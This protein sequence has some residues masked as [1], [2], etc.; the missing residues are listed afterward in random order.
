[1]CSG[2][3]QLSLLFRF[4]CFFNITYMTELL[5]LSTLKTAFPVLCHNGILMLG[6]IFCFPLSPSSLVSCLMYLHM[7]SGKA[8]L[9]WSLTTRWTLNHCFS[10]HNFWILDFFFPYRFGFSFFV[11]ASSCFIHINTHVY[12][13]IEALYVCMLYV[14]IIPNWI[15]EK[16]DMAKTYTN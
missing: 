1:M 8:S 14:Y 7:V 16:M 4:Y 3:I 15:A 2:W 12:T 5:L 11:S 13:Y 10:S 9:H 6:K